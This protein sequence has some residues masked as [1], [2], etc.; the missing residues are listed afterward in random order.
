MFHGWYPENR[1]VSFTTPHPPSLWVSVGIC[2]WGHGTLVQEYPSN[3]TFC[4]SCASEGL[5]PCLAECLLGPV[6]TCLV[7]CEVGSFHHGLVCAC[8][9]LAMGGGVRGK[10]L[11]PDK[12]GLHN[13]T[14]SKKK[15][16]S[17]EC[18][19]VTGHLTGVHKDLGLVVPTHIRTYTR[20]HRGFKQQKS[21]LEFTPHVFISPKP[22]FS[23]SAP[24]KLAQAGGQATAPETLQHAA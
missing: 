19:L 20:R 9:I 15:S 8:V 1:R 11:D 24:T 23:A 4:S 12:P 14:L 10:S 17:K 18:S 5:Q 16:K 6:P 13:K 7:H 22:H 21:S 3:T 2:R